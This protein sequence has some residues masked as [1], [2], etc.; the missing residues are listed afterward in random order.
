MP[1]ST[2]MTMISIDFTK[3]RFCGLSGFANSCPD[4]PPAT[5]A[6]AALMT[7]PGEFTRMAVIEPPKLAAQ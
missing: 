5:P 1:P 3:F 6:S 4:R 2:I 7:K